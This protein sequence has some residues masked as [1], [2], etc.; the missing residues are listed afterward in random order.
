M[1]PASAIAACC[2]KALA[3]DVVVYDMKGLGIEP[4][5][6]GEIVHDLPGGDWRRVQ[7]ATGYRSIIVNGV[8]TFTEGKCTGETPGRLLHGGRG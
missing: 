3:A 8:E 4:D 7:R 1:P 2:A 5:W 6:V